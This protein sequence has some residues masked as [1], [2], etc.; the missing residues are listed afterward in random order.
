MIWKNYKVQIFWKKISKS[1]CF[2][3]KILKSKASKTHVRKF[4]NIFKVFKVPMPGYKIFK[5]KLLKLFYT[6]YVF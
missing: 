1:E 3:K 5:R 4:Q 2:G 6:V